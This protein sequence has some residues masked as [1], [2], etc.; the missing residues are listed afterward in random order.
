MTTVVDPL[1][2]V[3]RQTL[4]SPSVSHKCQHH[5]KCSPGAHQAPI[6]NLSINYHQY[7]SSSYLDYIIEIGPPLPP[8]MEIKFELDTK[9]ASKAAAAIAAA[10]RLCH[11]SK[12][13]EFH[14]L[15]AANTIAQ[16]LHRDHLRHLPGPQ[17][18]NLKHDAQY[19]HPPI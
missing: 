8:V 7:F 15:T 10:Y 18:I 9:K 16:I 4:D 12:A 13:T 6:N 14:Q 11:V 2:S 19:N 17:Q 1:M 3:Y 5:E